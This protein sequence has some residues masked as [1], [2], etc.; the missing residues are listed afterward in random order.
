M[1]ASLQGAGQLG[2]EEMEITDNC[3]NS[4]AVM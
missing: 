1:E 4:L 2:D 3:L